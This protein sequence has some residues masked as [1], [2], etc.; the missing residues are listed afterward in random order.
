MSEVEQLETLRKRHQ[1]LA[2]SRT[3][4]E[5]LLE[6][7]RQELTK[8]EAE[9]TERYGTANLEELEAMLAAMEKENLEKRKS[10]QAQ[11]DAIERDLKDVE[12]KF[13]DE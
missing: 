2:E 3:R 4:A 8:L 10:Y 6:N 5:T 7:A 11:L 12:A 1:Q 9:A 13:K